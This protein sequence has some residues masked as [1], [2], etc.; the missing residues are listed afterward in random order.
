VSSQ[1]LA[2]TDTRCSS[3]ARQAPTD[4]STRDTSQAGF[5]CSPSGPAPTLLVLAPLTGSASDPVRD[6]STDVNRAA[7][8][9]LALLRD[10]AAGPCTDATN[11]VYTNAETAARSHS[12]HTWATTV[13][14]SPYETP[15]SGGRA[16]LTLWSSTADGLPHKGRLCITLRRASTG[17]IIG[18]SDFQLATWPDTPTELTTA[19]DLDHVALPAGER[20]LLTIRVPQDSG[21]DIRILYDHP[22]YA[23]SLGLTTIAGKE[24]K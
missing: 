5:T 6:F 16:S 21:S 14:A 15:T 10:T 2:L 4:H 22:K 17:T 11:L 23:S 8:G 7:T 24:L 13:P 12:I 19:F 3:V 9:G 18:S 20:L 1:N